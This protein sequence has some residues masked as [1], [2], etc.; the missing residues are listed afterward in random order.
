MSNAPRKAV[1]QTPPGLP[2]NGFPQI[3]GIDDDAKAGMANVV[4]F[5]GDLIEGFK[6]HKP[7]LT[8]LKEMGI[9]TRVRKVDG[10]DC[11]VIPIGELMTKEYLFMSG[12]EADAF[13][14]EE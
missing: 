1:A 11:I 7:V 5:V 13:K 14:V 6:K 12:V 10:E 3:P 2:A 4:K 8:S 9:K